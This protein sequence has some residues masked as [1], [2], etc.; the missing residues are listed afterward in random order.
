MHTI[1]ALEEAVALAEQLGYGIRQEWMGGCGGGVCQIAGRKWLF[2]DLSLTAPEQL[3][4]T[5]LALQEDPGTHGLSMSPQLSRLL[6]IRKS[7]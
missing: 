7:A 5:L 1:E 2:I 6:G 3:D 4:Q